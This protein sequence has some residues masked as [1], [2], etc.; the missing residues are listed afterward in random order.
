[1]LSFVPLGSRRGVAWN[2]SHRPLNHFDPHLLEV[3]TFPHG[4]NMAEAVVEHAALSI[5][6]R[7]DDGEVL[8]CPLHAFAGEVDLF[9]VET[10]QNT[11]VLAGVILDLVNLIE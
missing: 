9:G 11:D 3:L 8:V 4:L 1:M 6:P 5:V 10:E 7:P 2:E